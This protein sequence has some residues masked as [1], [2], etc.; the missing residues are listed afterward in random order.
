MPEQLKLPGVS[1][2]TIVIGRTGTGKTVMGVWLL[3]HYPLDQMPFVIIDF[4][5]DEHIEKIPYQKEC[6]FSYVPGQ[7]ETGIFVVHC[8]PYDCN[9]TGRGEDSP[10]DKYLLKL[11]A[12]ENIGVFV[13]E[14]YIVGDS[15]ALN[16]CLTQG[17]SKHIPMIL[18]SQRPAWVT[19]FAFS[20]ASYIS[21]FDLNDERDKDTV[22]GFTPIDF[23]EEDELEKYHSFWYEV[24]ENKVYRFAPVDPSSAAR[25]FEQKLSREKVRL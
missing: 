3:S 20:E 9:P 1:D 25:R 10:L 16:L 6:N 22:E 13:D 23:Y 4:K 7:K 12:R 18:C 8:T 21:V 15:E 11:W 19:R 17:R 5:G 2:R 24:G 14:A